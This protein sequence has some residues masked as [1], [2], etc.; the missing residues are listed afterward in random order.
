[1]N[2]S[3]PKHGIGADSVEVLLAVGATCGCA[4]T[5]HLSTAAEALLKDAMAGLVKP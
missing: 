5:S 4:A 3:R 2:T 1:M